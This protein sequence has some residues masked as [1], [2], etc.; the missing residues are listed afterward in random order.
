MSKIRIIGLLM[1]FLLFA[2]ILSAQTKQISGIVTD[3]KGEPV[4][5]AAVI[6][7]GSLTGMAT[8]LDGKY[9]ISAEKGATLEFS[10]VG[11]E[12]HSVIVGN[13]NQINIS[14]KDLAVGLEEVLVVG[15]GTQSKKTVTTAISRVSGDALLNKPINSVAD[16]LKGKI[17][18]AQVYSTNNSP[19]AEPTIRIRGGSSIDRS[20]DPLI[21]VDGVERDLA[22]I[23]PNDIASIEILKDAA[24]AAIYGSRASNGVVLVTT[25]RGSLNTAPTITFEASWAIENTERMMEYLGS[26]EALTLM[27][28]R[29][30]QSPHPNYATANNYA[31]SSGNTSTSIYSTRYLN[32]GEVVPNGYKSMVDPV[33]PS[34]KLIFM[35]NDWAKES[36]R[37]AL[38][39]NYYVGV[40]GGSEKIRYTGSVGYMN[41]GGVAV[42]TNFS[43]FTARSNADVQLSKRLKFTGGF[44]FNQTLT[45]EYPSQYQVLT[46]G[47]M[48]PTTQRLYYEDGDWAGTPTPGYNSSSPTPVFYAF[49]NDNDQKMNKLGLNGGL[50]LDIIDGLKAN[51]QTSLFT[52]TGT[53]DYFSRAN[54]RNG[55]RP[56]S[57]SLTDT[58]RQKLETY[59][60]YNK[61]WNE[62]HYLSAMAGYSYQKYKYKYLNAAAQDASSDKIPTL[63]AGPTKTEATT[64]MNEEVLIGYFG[65][66]MYDYKKKYMLMFT[67]REDA[68]SRFAKDNQW[69]FFPG[70]SAGWI[71]SDESFMEKAKSISNLKLRVSYGQT[72]NNSIGYYDALGLYAIGTKYEGESTIVPSAMPNRG[73]TWESSTQLDL[74][75]D[76][77]L[78]DNRIQLAGDYFNKL[79][80]NLIT[81]KILPN[82]SGFG[83]ILTNIG[84]VRFYGFD[85]ELTTR[86]IQTK[87]F[88]WESKIIWSYVKN[89]VEKLPDNGREGNR[90]GGYSVKMTDG[91]TQEFGGIAEGEPLGRFYGYKTDYIISTPEQANKALYDENSR[92]WDWQTKSSKGTGKKAV[93]DYEW[94]DLNGDAR[95]NGNDMFYLGTTMPH[96]TGGLNNTFAYKNF[97]LSIYFDWA[98]GHS[99][100]NNVLQRQMCNFF[101]NNTS[102]PKNVLEC[103]DPEAGQE[104]KD[105]QYARFGGN[106]S[107]DLNKNFRP[108]SNVFTTKGNYLCLRDVT[109]LYTIPTT[110]TSRL[111]IQGLAFTV[112]GN[113][114][115]YFTSVV[116]ISPETGT[117]DAY[118]SNYYSYPPIRKISFGL[119]LTL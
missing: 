99:V 10:Y 14:L 56:S 109:F 69:G 17:A 8:D 80:D 4:I 81:T 15:Y 97:S 41:D 34:K 36:F 54:I 27:R 53:G 24:S 31:Y 92:G 98:L 104:V 91:S 7:K 103:W 2:G 71:I 64:T 75:F 16:G 65:R 94:K 108:N 22:G 51:L 5:G 101:G 37:T 85:L 102:L 59:F 83:S 62:A 82:T 57:S 115:H 86:N 114:L 28:P 77:G 107:D 49:C 12:P 60:S 13:I 87:N 44:D 20:N 39:Q 111:G 79:T 9:T 50:D 89:Q 84:Q 35:D 47:M 21:L 93:G 105:A 118:S 18:G 38:W 1:A 6:V 68:S 42:G 66:F 110:L 88:S 58:Q 52:S 3:Q 72:G 116:G 30:L 26:E 55:S 32:E 78:F 76:L 96:S 70:V 48:T 90:I 45:N 46:R 19:G 74:G 106:D 11:Y 23:N 25:R 40:N 73:L 29:L 67:F 113:N 61:T 119:K 117:S 100:S 95:I 43:R 112:S 63:N 33:D